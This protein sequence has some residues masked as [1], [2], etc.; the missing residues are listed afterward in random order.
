MSIFAMSNPFQLNGSSEENG[1]E[2]AG[3]AAKIRK[4]AS[5]VKFLLG[6]K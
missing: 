2:S 6:K 4:P 1:D 5:F 3:T